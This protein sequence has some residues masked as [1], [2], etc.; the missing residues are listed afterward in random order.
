MADIAIILDNVGNDLYAQSAREFLTSPIKADQLK[1][2][3]ES[4]SQIANI[5]KIRNKS[6]F[7]N[8]ANRDISLRNFISATNKSNLIIDV[9]LSPPVVLDGS[10]YFEIILDP[11]STIY[12]MFYFD[13]QKIAELLT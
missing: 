13:Q 5:L 10:T 6:S 9:Q 3:L 4:E 7:G 11:A 2:L 8:E 1:I 12:L